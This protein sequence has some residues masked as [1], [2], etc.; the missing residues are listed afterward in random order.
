MVET[1]Q[2]KYPIKG[3]WSNYPSKIVKAR[4]VS[5]RGAIMTGTGSRMDFVLSPASAVCHK[6]GR[7]IRCKLEGDTSSSGLLGMRKGGR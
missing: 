6:D 3:G 2:Y 4:S 1:G 7:E 5:F